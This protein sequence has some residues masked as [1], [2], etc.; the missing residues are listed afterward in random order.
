MLAGMDL[1]DKKLELLQLYYP[2]YSAS[3]LSEILRGCHG[4]VAQARKLIDGPAKL[5]A[6]VQRTLPVKRKAEPLAPDAQKRTAQGPFHRTITLNTPDDVN[7]HLGCYAL[8]H[9]NFFPQELADGLLHELVSSK[10]KFHSRQFYLFGNLCQLNMMVAPFAARDN[11]CP[12]LVYNGLA[13]GG[14]AGPH[15]YTHRFDLAAKRLEAWMNETVI[16]GS[17][18]LPFQRKDRWKAGFCVVNMYEKLNNHLDWHLDRLSSIGP[19]NFIASVLLGLTRVFKLRSTHNTGPVYLVPLP[20]NSVFLMR[21]GCQEE[22][23]HTLGP[24]AKLVLLHPDVGSLR[25]SLTFRHYPADFIRNLPKCRC[26]IP[27]MLRRA[28]KSK[29]TRGTY[30]WLC[31]NVYQNKDCGAFEWANF[32]NWDGHFIATSQEVASRWLAPE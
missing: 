22:Y 4:D 3:V 28:F 21:P 24:M 29:E 8:L 2:G 17:K 1:F 16:P 14:S 19:H 10:D 26:D 18:R 7:E 31:E 32:D 13:V 20:H 12:A 9:L 30:F 15:E 25:I 11:D 23:K 6:P 27:M 5:K